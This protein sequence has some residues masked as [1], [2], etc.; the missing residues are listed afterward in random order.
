MWV[1]R[2]HFGHI[3]ENITKHSQ[4]QRRFLT[5][6]A[7]YFICIPGSKLRHF[8]MSQNILRWHYLKHFPK[9]A[10][11][12]FIITQSFRLR[13]TFLKSSSLQSPLLYSAVVKDTSSYGKCPDSAVS[14]NNHRNCSISVICSYDKQNVSLSFRRFCNHTI[15]TRIQLVLRSILLSPHSRVLPS[16]WRKMLC[17]K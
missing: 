3:A 11:C 2:R 14:E 5:S 7:W 13:N 12:N 1:L 17:Y 8:N 6:S 16:S 9:M 15:Y 4:N 10:Q